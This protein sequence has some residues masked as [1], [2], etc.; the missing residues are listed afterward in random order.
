MTD[1][2]RAAKGNHLR[3]KGVVWTVSLN[4]NGV[5]HLEDFETGETRRLSVADWQEGCFDG[6]VEMLQDPTAELPADRKD[7]AQ[8]TFAALPP[9]MQAEVERMRPYIEA[10]LDPVAFYE[11]RM[12]TLPPED[13]HMPDRMSKAKVEPFLRHVASTFDPVDR[14]PG[15]TTFAGWVR[16]WRRYRDWKLMAPRYDCRGSSDRSVIVGPLQEIVDRAI[17]QVWMTRGRATKKAV[18]EAVERAVAS[19]NERHPEAPVGVSRRQVYRYMDEAIDGYEKAVARHGKPWADKRFRPLSK[20]PGADRVMQVVEADHTQAKLEVTDD[21]TGQNLGRPWITAAIDR[22]SRMV[23]GLHVHFEGQTL[24]AVLQGLRNA[25]MPKGF[26]RQLVPELDYSYPCCGTPERYFFDRGRDF[27]NDHVVEVGLNLDIQMAY[28]PGENPGYKGSIERF[29]GTLHRQV[30]LPLKGAT[31]RVADRA[32]DRRPRKSE[33]IVPFSDFVERLWRWVTMVYAQEFHEGLGNTPLAVWTESAGVRPP[34]PPPTK[35][36]L[37]TYLMRTVRC[38]PTVNGVRHAGLA[39]NGDVIKNIR[40][41]PSHQRGGQILVRI[42]DT[43]LGRAFATDPVTGMLMPL[44]PVLDRYM[45]GLSMHAH[46]LIL[47]NVAKR[48]TG[49]HSE[50]SLMEAKHQL[51]EEALATLAMKDTKSKTRARLA[52][53]FNVGGTAPSGDDLG[54]LDPRQE[55]VAASG[56]TEPAAAKAPGDREQLEEARVA[57]PPAPPAP[58]QPGGRRS[59]PS[60][61]L[62]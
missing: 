28:A 37:D 19:R 56:P 27:D 58:G 45:P 32:S 25:M 61:R 60:R 26:L 57:P 40:S 55:T 31:P 52:R 3:W 20:G 15:F 18:C 23:V 46:E 42:D 39:W 35:E 1:W 54:S 6:T 51:R 43:D 53:L 14:K 12:P 17:K 38:E 22:R 24:N 33:A 4:L 10:Y 44:K 13:R 62:G 29:F 16:R 21:E 47:R 8:L 5:L 9:S 2:R 36:R 34:R 41:H 50:R 30:A 7:L 49:T 48:R 11:S 59:A